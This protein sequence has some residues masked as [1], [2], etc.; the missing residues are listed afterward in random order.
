MLPLTK[1]N[2]ELLDLK[3]YNLKYRRLLLDQLRWLNRNSDNILSHALTLYN[4]YVNNKL[5]IKMQN[6]CCNFKML[7][8]KCLEY[9]KEKQTII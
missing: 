7:E 6:R 4:K 9:N 3:K 8:E 2:Y 5:S 1:N